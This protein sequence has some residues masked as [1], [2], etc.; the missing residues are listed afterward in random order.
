M[1]KQIQFDA[2]GADLTY[3]LEWL[4]YAGTNSEYQFKRLSGKDQL[5]LNKTVEDAAWACAEEAAAEYAEGHGDWIHTM[6]KDRD[7]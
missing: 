5:R 2:S 1:I 6:A 7:L 4:G 3:D